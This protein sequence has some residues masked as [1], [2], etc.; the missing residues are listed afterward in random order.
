VAKI[1]RVRDMHENNKIPEIGFKDRKRERETLVQGY[2]C[3]KIVV[4]MNIFTP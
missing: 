4:S 3:P 2:Y 1:E